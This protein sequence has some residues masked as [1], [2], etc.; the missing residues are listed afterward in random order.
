MHPNVDLHRKQRDLVG[1][2]MTLVS[3]FV[4]FIA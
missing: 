3:A 1:E 4:A 2:A